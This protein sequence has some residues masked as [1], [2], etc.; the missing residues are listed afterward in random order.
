MMLIS[1]FYCLFLGFSFF[2]LKIWKEIWCSACLMSCW[3]SWFKAFLAISALMR[4]CQSVTD[5]A[6]NIQHVCLCAT[7]ATEPCII[8]KNVFFFDGS[9]FRKG[10]NAW[11]R[12]GPAPFS[13]QLSGNSRASSVIRWI[14]NI[15]S[16]SG[17]SSFCFTY[18]IHTH[19]RCLQI[20]LNIQNK[21][22][23]FCKRS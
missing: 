20:Y 14:K 23:C 19:L 13:V 8:G 22:I 11:K 12:C 9:S 1:Y 10:L 17:R 21:M 15:T 3:S 18:F 7:V 5:D 4:T 2:S 16:T 6:I